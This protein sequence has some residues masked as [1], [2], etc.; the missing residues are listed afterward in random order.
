MKM[1]SVLA[2]A[3]IAGLAGVANA[4]TVVTLTY[5]DLSGNYTGNASGGTFNA[6]AVNTADLHSAGDVARIIPTVGTADFEPG[7]VSGG[8]SANFS[9]NMTLGSIISGTR[10]GTGSFTSTDANGDT[11]TG[12]MSGVWALVGSYLAYNGVLSNV[13]FHANTDSSF[14]GSHTGSFSTSDL[15]NQVYSGAIV[16]LTTSPDGGFFNGD[17]RDSAT[18]INAQ[19]TTVPLPPAALAGLATIAGMVAVRRIR[20]R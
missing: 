17:F 3:S 20:R 14:D 15:V 18:G 8:S 19:V 13:V 9:L 7:F 4:A 16:N 6:H 2:M 10:S 1:R 11:I 12:D 5:T